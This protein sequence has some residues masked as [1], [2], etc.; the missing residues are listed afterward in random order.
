MVYLMKL[1][2]GEPLQQATKKDLHDLG[3][4]LVWPPE[5]T[6]ESKLKKMQALLDEEKA[7]TTDPSLT[8]TEKVLRVGDLKRQFNVYNDD[9]PTRRI[10]AVPPVP[11]AEI[12]TE[13]D[14]D[15]DDLPEQT[16]LHATELLKPIVAYRRGKAR[17]MLKKL[18]AAGL[19][20][21]DAQGNV[22]YD[23]KPIRGAH[24]GDLVHYFQ[25]AHKKDPI[26]PP[27]AGQVLFSHALRHAGATE[28]IRLGGV[29]DD[30]V[31]KVFRGITPK[32]SGKK[33][34]RQPTASGVYKPGEKQVEQLEY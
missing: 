21:W 8:D 9:R 22:I 16:E 23:G 28:D 32:R 15:D 24:M 12:K 26:K 7:V 4:K 10:G 19:L 13:D 14:E 2:E 6:R 31:R 33:K 17:L 34:R 25:T 20:K 18:A 11:L 29:E 3:E 27:P 5:F 30:E 1:T